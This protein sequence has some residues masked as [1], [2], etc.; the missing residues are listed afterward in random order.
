[1]SADDN[2]AIVGQFMEEV[3]NRRQ[4]AALGRLVDGQATDR[5]QSS[6]TLYLVL[7]AFPDFRLSVEHMIADGDTVTVLSTF[8]GTHQGPFMGLP[9]TGR[10]VR[11]R[12]ANTFRV[13][14]G[15]IVDS[16][17]NFDPWGLIQQL[18]VLGPVHTAGA[19]A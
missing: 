11:G 15:K 1:M 8:T 13:V 10:G 19:T 2:K 3:L 17:Q 12:M 6:L 18:G 14:D 4:P 5:L 9:P 16:W 7:T